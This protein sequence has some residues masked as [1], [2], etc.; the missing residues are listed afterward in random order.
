[1]DKEA[2]E[3]HRHYCV[4][5][6]MFVYFADTNKYAFFMIPEGNTLEDVKQRELIIREF[7][8]EWKERN[9]LQRKYNLALKE[10]INIRMVSIVETSEHAAKSYLS[11]LAVLQLDAILVGAR[12]ISIKKVKPNNKNQQPFERMMIMEYELIG[13]GTIKM[14]VGVRRRTH[15]KVQY[16]ITAI[17]NK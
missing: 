16:C 6:I 17:S 10:Y 8:R 11:T 3:K 7:Y 1:M 14:T 2:R 12:K 13:I 15:E 9:P 4:S 5:Q